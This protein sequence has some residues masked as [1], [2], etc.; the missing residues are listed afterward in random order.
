MFNA[1][2]IILCSNNIYSNVDVREAP[3]VQ[4][5]LTFLG[6]FIRSD[7]SLFSGILRL[8]THYL[9]IAMRE[10]I[11]QANACDSSDALELLMQVT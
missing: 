7:P 10:E 5:L 4:E 9:I 2:C 11:S 8:R 6:Q 3:F 1:A